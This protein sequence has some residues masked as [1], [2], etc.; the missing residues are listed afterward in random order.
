MGNQGAVE[1]PTNDGVSNILIFEEGRKWQQNSV[2]I[3]DIF[4]VWRLQILG[5]KRKG[6]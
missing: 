5:Q 2:I 6:D 1:I 4:E 3:S